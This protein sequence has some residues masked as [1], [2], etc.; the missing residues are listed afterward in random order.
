[1]N[2]WDI[3]IGLILAAIIISAIIKII[4]NKKSGKCSCGSCS[5]CSG[6]CSWKTS[7]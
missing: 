6:N 7:K 3:I 2:I 5:A 1:M 4:K